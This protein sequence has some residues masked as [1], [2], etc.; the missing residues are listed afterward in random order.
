MAELDART[1]MPQPLKTR[2]CHLLTD[3]PNVGHQTLDMAMATSQVA[4]T[5]QV[6]QIWQ[7]LLPLSR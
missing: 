7:L 5:A 6:L 3:V 2:C 1:Q 4:T